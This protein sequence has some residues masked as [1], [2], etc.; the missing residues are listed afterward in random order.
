MLTGIQHVIKVLR[1]ER[2]E[3]LRERE[4]EREQDSNHSTDTTLLSL[5]GTFFPY[6]TLSMEPIDKVDNSKE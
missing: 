4:R 3:P 1:N 2:N 6:L 5:Q